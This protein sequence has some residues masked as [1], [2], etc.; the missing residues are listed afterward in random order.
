MIVEFHSGASE[1]QLL[2]ASKWASQRIS[3]CLVR[4]LESS[5][6]SKMV[7]LLH[8]FFL[9]VNISEIFI[10]KYCSPNTKTTCLIWYS[11]TKFSGRLG[12]SLAMMINFKKPKMSNIWKIKHKLSHKIS[13]RLLRSIWI[14]R[15][16]TYLLSNFDYQQW[17]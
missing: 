8:V 9:N 2:F 11:N 6:P 4:K 7:L 12:W 15:Y 14:K 13:K 1:I 10:N 17:I 5:L 3:L 16:N